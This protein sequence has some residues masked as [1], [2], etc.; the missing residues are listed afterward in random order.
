M[1]TTLLRNS[2]L[3]QVKAFIDQ[4]VIVKTFVP[5][6]T[7]IPVSGKV[8]DG[9]D[10]AMLV[11]ACLDGWLTGGRFT[12]QF[13][14]DLTHVT[15][16]RF[17]CFVNSGSSANLLAVSALTSGLL[18]ERALKPGDE[19]ITLAAG[20]PTT[21]NPIIQN[22]LVP[23]F[24]D[25]DLSTMNV[26]VA[27]LE[28][29]IG[30]RTKAIILAHTLGNPFNINA[31]KAI[32][33]K[34][35]L[36]LIEDSC[37]ALGA[38][39]D[40]KSVGGFGD[41]ATL[42]F[43]PAHHITTGEGGA[44]LTSSALLNKIILSFRDWGRD[45]W[46]PTGK[47]NTCGKRFEWQLGSLPKGYDHKYIY[48]H[49]GYNL[50]ATD[51]QAALGVSQIKKLPDFV[52]ARRANWAALRYGLSTLEGRI[53]FV[54]PTVGSDPSWFGFVICLND[55][56]VSR[57][58][59]VRHLESKKIGTRMLFG[60]NLLSHPAYVGIT[61][62]QVGDLSASQRV[63]DDVLWVGVYPGIT[64]IITEYMID[65]INTFFKDNA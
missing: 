34:Y 60:G 10:Q 39:Y 59:L 53:S 51:M 18:N 5:G 32:A 54:S 22:N 42:S 26:D 47:D 23:V 57:D 50:K 1:N 49:I 37:D 33:A 8:L 2:I 14:K 4:E 44:V 11:D 24:V 58:M 13:E 6:E 45:C 16:A 21:V 64:P 62:R 25:I 29:A 20:F 52:N 46:C 7:Y 28:A 17:A 12:D 63:T 15:G 27:S 38:M 61:C 35:H 40:G 36:W 30:P 31:V 9:Q 55:P 41:I 56:K 65:T 43:Y 3:T 19:V 48:S